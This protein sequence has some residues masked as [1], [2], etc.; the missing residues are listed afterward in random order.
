MMALRIVGNVAAGGK[1]HHRVGAVVHGAMQLFEFFVDVRGGRGVADVGVDLAVE[2]DADAHRLEVA[3]MDVGG[4]D[5]AAARDFAA[6]QFRLELFAPRDVLHLFGDDAL[7]R[8]VHL[9]D[10]SRRHSRRPFAA[11]SQS[12]HL[13]TP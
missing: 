7:P 12:M 5:G 2:G 6:D 10:V 8:V 4:D 9:R 13:L 11:A 1:I 3:V